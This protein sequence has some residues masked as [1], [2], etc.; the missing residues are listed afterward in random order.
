MRTVLA[1]LLIGFICVYLGTYDSNAVAVSM[2][3]IAAEMDLDLVVV[4]WVP[5]GVVV[6]S[7]SLLLVMGSLADKVGHRRV[8]YGGFA[9]YAAAALLAAL[10]SGLVMLLLARFL[11][12]IAFAVFFTVGPAY[13]IRAFVPRLRSRALSLVG[14]TT[15]IG[16]VSGPFIGGWLTELY[17]WRS[18]F[19]FPLAGLVLVVLVITIGSRLGMFERLWETPQRPERRFDL[20]GAVLMLAWQAPLLAVLTLG[21]GLGWL[22]WPVVAAAVLGFAMLALF[23][24]LQLATDHPTVDFRLFKLRDFRL[25]IV[26]AFLGFTVVIVLFTM[27]P[28]YMSVVLGLAPSSIAPVMAIGPAMMA[29]MAPLAAL[30]AEHTSPRRPAG[31]GLTVVAIGIGL[32]ALLLRSDSPY[33]LLLLLVPVTGLGLGTF[34]WTVNSSIVGS[35]PRSMLG[36]S[37]GFLATA[38]T[39]GFSFGPALWGV[40]FTVTVTSLSGAGLALDAPS[41]T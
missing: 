36:V 19:W 29:F 13:T 21:N 27:M 1:P 9:V 39:F 7:G 20:R 22:S 25:P 32:L 28:F 34:E 11:F 3:V 8:L 14:V 5:L 12:G 18:L 37:A 24:R 26:A 30:W 4:Q 15:S 33:W 2:P 16:L 10:S 31:L 23:V 41:T 17:G 6:T 35:L 38:R 40:I